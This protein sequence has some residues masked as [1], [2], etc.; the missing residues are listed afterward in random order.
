SWHM[1]NNNIVGMFVL[2]VSSTIM[3]YDPWF[4][5]VG[6][7]VVIIGSIFTL[8]SFASGR[9]FI[10]KE[11][12][13]LLLLLMLFTGYSLLPAIYNYTLDTS[14]FFMYFK[15]CIYYILCFGFVRCFLKKEKLLFVLKGSVVI[16]CVFILL[17]LISS[18]VRNFIFSVHTVEDRFLISEQAYRLY[19]L[20]SS[21]FFQLSLF[22]GFLFHFMV[23]LY[24]ENK[25]GLLILILIFV[26]GAFSGRVFFLF[27]VISVIF[28]G[29]NIRYVPLYSVI[30]FVLIFFAIKF[31]DNIFIR[32]ALEPLINYINTG[33]FMTAS[34]DKLVEKMLFIPDFSAL[35]VGDGVYYNDDGSYYMHT[36][37]GIIRQFLYGGGGYF[38]SCMALTWYL[39]TKVSK[40]WL[41]KNKKFTLSTMIIFLIGNIKADVLMYPGI[42]IN[43]IF[44]LIF[45]SGD[46]NDKSV[47][48]ILK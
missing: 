47:Y 35:V 2:I 45:A 31:S 43:L 38:I 29:I 6:R 40:N 36:D 32:H 21:S 12:V 44:I 18:D 10:R 33:E 37:S 22:F 34:S 17:C 11:E 1:K 28:Y 41:E 14:V 23:A 25:V 26:C 42:M 24:K 5:G 8:I 15:M 7:G 46:N 13:K 20:S 3:I 19:F 30:A 16:Q 39:L 4:F 48:R 27:A 9:F